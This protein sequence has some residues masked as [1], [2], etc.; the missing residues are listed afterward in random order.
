MFII[1]MEIKIIRVSCIC[2]IWYVGF[3][4][5]TLGNVLWKTVVW[6][7]C[8]KSIE[9]R[10]KMWNVKWEKMGTRLEKTGKVC[11]KIEGL[12]HKESVMFWWKKAKKECVKDEKTF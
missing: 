8:L 4:W 2:V 11:E 9:K 1:C 5:E 6:E 10:G 7:K 12:L 3:A